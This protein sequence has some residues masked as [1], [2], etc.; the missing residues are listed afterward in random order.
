MVYVCMYIYV[1]VIYLYQNIGYDKSKD[2]VVYL[3]SK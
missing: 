2:H 3:A 1:S